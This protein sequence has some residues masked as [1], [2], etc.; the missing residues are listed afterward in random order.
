[1]PEPVAAWWARRQRAR[2]AEVP[3]PVG[4]YRE[5]WRPY[6]VLV[7][8]YHADLNGGVALSQIPPA[9]EVLLQWQCDLGHVFVA[10]PAEQRGKPGSTAQRRRSV[11]CPECRAGADPPRVRPAQTSEE[12]HESL[13]RL[14]ARPRKVRRIC[15]ETPELPV[16]ASFASACAPKIG[17]AVEARLHLALRERYAFETEHTAVRVAQPFFDH[18]EVWPDVVI[19]ELRVAIEYDT[20]GRHGLEH[21]GRREASDLRK[22]RA[23]R[24]AGWEVVRLRTSPLRA[25][26]PHDLE[27]GVLGPRA[28]DRLDARLGELRGELFLAAYRR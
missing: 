21:V 28:L 10:T 24:R 23:L 13:Q 12:R 16:G 4:T 9:A 20:S 8:Q 7:R 3:Y 14:A 18:L 26:G 6:P 22:D 5:Q 15:T 1:M 27:I 17:S 11:W 2:G 19:P 25:L